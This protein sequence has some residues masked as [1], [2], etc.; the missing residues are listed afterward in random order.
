MMRIF[1]ANTHCINNRDAQKPAY[2]QLKSTDYKIMNKEVEEKEERMTKI[3]NH[4]ESEKGSKYSKNERPITSVNPNRGLKKLIVDHAG[5][6]QER[7]YSIKTYNNFDR[8]GN[9]NVDLE[10]SCYNNQVDDQEADD[11]IGIMNSKNSKET[12]NSQKF[13]FDS[14]LKKNNNYIQHANIGNPEKKP[15]TKEF[16][17]LDYQW[18]VDNLKKI[19]DEQS[20][21]DNLDGDLDSYFSNLSSLLN[22]AHDKDQNK[23]HHSF[24][25]NNEYLSK[26]KVQN[27]NEVVDIYKELGL[28]KLP[29]ELPKLESKSYE[30][31]IPDYKS[32][33]TN[34]NFENEN[35]NINNAS[36]Y[37]DNFKPDYYNPD[38]DSILNPRLPQYGYN[39]NKLNEIPSWKDSKII[40]Y[41]QD[42]YHE[43]EEEEHRQ[44]PPSSFGISKITPST[45]INSSSMEYKYNYPNHVASD[46]DLN[47][48]ERIYA[49]I[50]YSANPVQRQTPYPQT[51]Q[52][53]ESKQSIVPPQPM[54]FADI[55]KNQTKPQV[56]SEGRNIFAKP[57][58]PI[59]NAPSQVCLI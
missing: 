31:Y 16:D 5:D 23:E 28:P 44:F 59:N 19:S 39:K 8:K 15:E 47:E 25:F 42:V 43:S 52:V 3:L 46:H 41:N 58:I 4:N 18:N 20:K 37:Y 33:Y 55:L 11:V 54:C 27:V 56:Q 1:I 21:Y 6:N 24:Q 17:Y 26:D 30:H 49:P 10:T 32:T 51:R 53:I 40:N 29:D 35:P 14:M 45:T 34:E 12:V 7:G 50:P 36:K 13:N 57:S 9:Q 2:T 38:I 22:K 48:E